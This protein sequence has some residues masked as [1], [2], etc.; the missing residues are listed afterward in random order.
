M[1]YLT[2]LALLFS[3]TS[4]A[5]P[6]APDRIREAFALSG[7]SKLELAA[8]ALGDESLEKLLQELRVQPEK[9]PKV[10]DLLKKL[11]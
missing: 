1:K 3:S 9:E 2:L 8:E 4:F 5:A 11:K 6:L 10:K 7:D